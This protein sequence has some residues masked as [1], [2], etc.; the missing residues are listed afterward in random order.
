MFLIS[1]EMAGNPVMC[2]LSFG[3]R[4]GVRT[5]VAIRRSE[6]GIFVATPA[7][8]VLTGLVRSLIGVTRPGSLQEPAFYS[9]QKRQHD[10]RDYV[11]VLDVEIV[12]LLRIC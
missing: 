6:L 10:G 1:L 5:S 7:Q 8:H 3:L 12:P 11:S 4:S 2:A 9:T